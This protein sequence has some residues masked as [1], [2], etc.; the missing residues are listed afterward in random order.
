M[1]PM[2]PSLVGSPELSPAGAAPASP[3]DP[4]PRWLGSGW[5]ALLIG[6]F[7]FGVNLVQLSRPAPWRDEAAS[8][9]SGQRSPGELLAMLGHIDAVHGGY[10]F[11]LYG[12]E[13]LFGDSILSLRLVSAVAVGLTAGLVFLLARELFG[14]ASAPWAGLLAALLPPST[15]AAT[16]ARSTALSCAATAAAM[17]ALAVALRRDSGR[18]WTLWAV[19]A[20]VSIHLFLYSGLAFVGLLPALIALPAKTRRHALVAGAAVL[21]CCLPF[22]LVVMS[23]GGQLAWLSRHQLTLTEVTVQTFWRY[24]QPTGWIGNALLLAGLAALLSRLR[25]AGLRPAIC[26]V[27]GWLVG[28]PLIM[29]AANLLRPV[30]LARYLSFT[31]GA[32]ALVFG[33]LIGRLPRLWLR[34]AV[35]ALLCLLLVPSFLQARE[36]YS[37]DT[38]FGAYLELQQVAQPGDG[39]LP[40]GPDTDQPFWAFRSRMAGLVDLGQ[41]PDPSWRSVRLYPTPRTADAIAATAGPSR[42]WLLT[43]QG[44]PSPAL[45]TATAAFESA[46]YRA[47]QPVQLANEL[48]AVLVERS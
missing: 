2:P 47:A 31:V 43:K 14:A 45:S 11:L 39:V 1:K 42:I 25:N 19:T 32:L 20:V 22:A 40:L 44:L 26:L 33:F 4:G 34:S 38:S 41:D 27:V 37:K 30:Y 17:L 10:Y 15:W 21:A 48:V 29:A 8:W 7:G 23:Q 28:P 36:V 9:I 6:G 46:G 18:A 12:W 5:L 16:E 3:R 35:T 13:R 24:D